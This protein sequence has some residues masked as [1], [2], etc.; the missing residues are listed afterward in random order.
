MLQAIKDSYK[1]IYLDSFNRWAVIAGL[2][3]ALV[4]YLIWHMLGGKESFSVYSPYGYYPLQM[5]AIVWLLH[6]II[7]VYSYKID[8]KISYLLTSALTF[9]ALLIIVLE[10]YYWVS[11]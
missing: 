10:I 11:L 6:L 5:L 3:L 9:Y 8:K 2:A 7:A 1:A 4:N